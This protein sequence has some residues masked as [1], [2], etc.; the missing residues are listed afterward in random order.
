MEF[1][2]EIYQ[3]QETSLKYYKSHVKNQTKDY[4][5]FN[6]NRFFK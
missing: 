4:L 5:F 2:L 1:K 3:K 6:Q